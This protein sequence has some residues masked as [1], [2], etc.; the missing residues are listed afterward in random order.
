MM[1]RCIDCGARFKPPW[2][3]P[4]LRVCGKCCP[5]N[6]AMYRW[7]CPDGRSYVGS[8]M[9]IR[10]RQGRLGRNNVR[11]REALKIYPAETWR[12]EILERLEF[13]SDDQYEREQYHIDRLRT[14]DPQYGFNIHPAWKEEMDIRDRITVSVA[15]Q[16]YQPPRTPQL[17]KKE[18]TEIRAIL[19]IREPAQ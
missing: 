15:D 9:D 18:A 19:G 13:Y 8:Q 6:T 10:G 7:I 2:R 5:S 4:S 1:K 17:S 11:L 12:F 16:F 14:L 3:S